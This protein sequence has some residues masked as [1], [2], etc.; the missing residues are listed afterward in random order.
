[1]PVSRI[2]AGALF[3]LCAPPLAAQQRRAL[4]SDDPQAQV[5]GYF[6]ALFQVTPAGLAPSVTALGGELTFIPALSA[7]ERRVGF[8]GT[9]DENTNL[10]PVLPRLRAVFVREAGAVEAGLV[11]PLEVCGVR[12]LLLGV[13]I[14]RRFPLDNDF[15]L[16]VRA[17]GLLGR[18]SAPI[19][20]GPEAVADSL[21]LT[22]FMGAVSDDRLAPASFAVEAGVYHGGRHHRR[23]DMYAL[24]GVRHEQLQFDVNFTR[25]GFGSYPTIDDHERFSARL[26][27]MHVLAGAG[28]R[29][30]ARLRAG[31]ELYWAP[32]AVFTVR[33]SA[34]FDLGRAR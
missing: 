27:R 23:L 19:T 10:C 14:S 5:M 11:P 31:A 8:G 18:V 34:S 32:G 2:I 33:S 22:C 9:K 24:L 30:A 7:A 1:M 26:T 25:A 17:S 28:Y 20:C 12:A 4:A 29:F 16:V 13:A 3:V 6:S 21:D 15:A